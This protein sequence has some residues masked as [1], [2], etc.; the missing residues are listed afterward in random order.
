[1]E[2]RR[3]SSF[4]GTSPPLSH[5]P[6]HP[7]NQ[8][9]FPKPIKEN[10]TSGIGGLFRKIRQGSGHPFDSNEIGPLPN[11]TET[12][13]NNQNPP[14]QVYPQHHLSTIDE[15]KREAIPRSASPMGNMM[16]NGQ[17]LD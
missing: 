16:L 4:F 8:T 1:N 6:V 11:H 13:P 10:T 12:P 17:M 9:E 7:N 2:T 14:P 5:P 15:M 3:K